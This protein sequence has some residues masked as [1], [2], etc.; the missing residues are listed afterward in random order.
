[1][2]PRGSWLDRVCI[3]CSAVIINSLAKLFVCMGGSP[4]PFIV[5]L[6]GA[7]QLIGGHT[8]KRF[9]HTHSRRARDSCQRHDTA[10]TPSRYTPKIA[11]TTGVSLVHRVSRKN[12][13]S[14]GR[15]RDIQ[16]VT[17]FDTRSSE[18]LFHFLV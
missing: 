1:V 8:R 10:A 2:R 16:D 6:T 4:T 18:P 13:E 9:A 14:I 15:V 12:S 5:L 3:A 7:R 17:V 11:E